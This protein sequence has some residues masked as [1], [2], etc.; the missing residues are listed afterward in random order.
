M[1]V[2]LEACPCPVCLQLHDFGLPGAW[3]VWWEGDTYVFT[4]PTTGQKG[5]LP[6]QAT[7]GMPVNR[8]PPSAVVLRGR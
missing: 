2:L 1:A 4:C 3:A 5:E 7:P 6:K 8:C